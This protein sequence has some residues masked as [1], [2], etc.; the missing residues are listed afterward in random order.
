MS[1]K[2]IGSE[3]KSFHPSAFILAFS[4][5]PLAGNGLGKFISYAALVAAIKESIRPLAGNGLGKLVEGLA[6]GSALSCFRP[7]AGNGLGKDGCIAAE[8]NTRGT[9]C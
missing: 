3:A 1:L 4:F 7:L 6:K 2:R 8:R 9:K 5:R